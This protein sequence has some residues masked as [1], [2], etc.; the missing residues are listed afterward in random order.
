MR[1]WSVRSSPDE[2]EVQEDDL[3]G[4]GVDEDVAG[5]RVAVEEAVD[6]DLLDHRRG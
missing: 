1:R 2:P 5:V 3:P 6:E 4:V